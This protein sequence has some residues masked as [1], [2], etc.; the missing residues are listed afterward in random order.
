MRHGVRN[1]AFALR[2]AGDG[3]RSPDVADLGMQG[4]HAG[5]AAPALSGARTRANGPPGCASCR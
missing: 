5:P 4:V 3:P 1:R 2:D